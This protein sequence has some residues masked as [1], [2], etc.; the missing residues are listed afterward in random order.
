[1]SGQRG[2]IVRRF[3]LALVLM[4]VFGTSAN[5]RVW[6]ISNTVQDGASGFGSGETAPT[7]GLLSWTTGIG[8]PTNQRIYGKSNTGSPAVWPNYACYG[9]YAAP[10][11]EPQK[12]QCQQLGVPVVW[13]PG[14]TTYTGGMIDDRNLSSASN[15]FSWT[16]QMSTAV[17]VGADLFVNSIA[18]GTYFGDGT[19]TGTDPGAST[20]GDG[21]DADGFSCWNNPGAVLAF[22]ADFC[23]NGT[24]AATPGSLTQ[25]IAIRFLANGITSV[26]DNG[27]GTINV[28]IADTTYS[29][30]AAAPNC[31]PGSGSVDIT[32][33]WRF[34]ATAAVPIP[35]TFWM[36]GSALGLLGWMRRRK[37]V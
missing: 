35:A 15:S 36:F 12:V 37:A 9:L 16:G 27:D 32:A 10:Y 28:T 17:L 7:I 30:C 1:V 5:A 2:N 8:E 33:V 4:L 19:A 20:A 24:G 6:T 26:V 34:N 3:I 18:S 23:G 14:P 13:L 25:T 21:Y 11:P 22:G 31:V 29:D